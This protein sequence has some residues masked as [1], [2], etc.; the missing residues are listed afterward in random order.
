[1]ADVIGFN[2]RDAEDLIAGIG[3]GDN[4]QRLTFAGVRFIR[5]QLTANLTTV[6]TT[7]TIYDAAGNTIATGAT[8]EDPESIFTGLTNTTRGI[9]MQQGP[10]YFILNANCPA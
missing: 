4:V 5:F 6:S 9:G 1:M 10:R 7:A 2:S 8:I 3:K